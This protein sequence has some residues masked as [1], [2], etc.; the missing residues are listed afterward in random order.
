MCWKRCTFF[1]ERVNN[2]KD[3]LSCISL[4]VVNEV[5]LL[6]GSLL[7]STVICG[8]CQKFGIAKERMEYYINGDH[9]EEA[10]GSLQL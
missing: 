2:T 6:C 9:R 1:V 3:Y 4:Y 8:I 7:T 5:N 10:T